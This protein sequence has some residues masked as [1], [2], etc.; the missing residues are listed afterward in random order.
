M[1]LRKRLLIAAAIILVLIA[2]SAAA[3]FAAFDP[4]Q[5]GVTGSIPGDVPTE[6]VG[7]ETY[8]EYR[9]AK[10]V[11]IYFGLRN[12]SG[13]GVTV[14][15]IGVT[16]EP[17]SILN[18]EE[19]RLGGLHADAGALE[20]SRPFHSF[21]LH[22]GEERIV[23]LIGRLGNCDGEPLESNIGTLGGFPIHYRMAG[24]SR[25]AMFLIRGHSWGVVT[26]DFKNCPL[27]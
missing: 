1:T 20:G 13:W 26:P 11:V 4:F 23:Y 27:F 25:K 5:T 15:S 9:D 3:K 16:P 17:E 6:E 12:G 7:I 19:I 21:A 24:I 18:F 14:T 22:P 8:F 2:I 10:S